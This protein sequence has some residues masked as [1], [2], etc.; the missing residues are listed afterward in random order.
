MTSP[1]NHFTNNIVVN[2]HLLEPCQ[3]KCKY[4]YSEW[5]K[6]PLAEVY[7]SEEKSNHLIAQTAMLERHWAKVRI[8][9]A[10]GEPL[11]DK[12]LTAKI[13]YAHRRQLAV[14]I[15]TNGD[16]LNK[17]FLHKNAE[18]ISILGVSIDSLDTGSNLKIG[19]VTACG[20]HA[21]YQKIINLLSLARRI[22]PH[23]HI[24]I[25]TVVNQY[26]FN[27]DLSVLIDRVK[28]DKWKVFQVLP[29]TSK[30][31]TQAI[32][33]EQFGI[34]QKRHAHIPCAF[35]EDNDCMRNSYLM[36]DPYGRFFF[37][38]RGGGYGYSTPILDVGI[39]KALAQTDFDTAK[40]INRYPHG[41]K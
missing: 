13:D 2:W 5:G 22:N 17:K 4:C 20:R 39:E 40:F 8:S 29:A 30:S 16:L 18:K 9:F 10:G 38:K 1:S 27:E 32:S 37:N 41:V 31:T 25:N 21:N 34:F 15:I 36:I 26:N 6:V 28:P 3:F 14:S 11:L 23:I 12:N 19:R 24:K 33:A 35:F 7:K